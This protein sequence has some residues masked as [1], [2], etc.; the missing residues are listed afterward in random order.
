MRKYTFIIDIES[1]E[2]LGADS[3]HYLLQR[4]LPKKTHLITQVIK[5]EG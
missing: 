1:K 4:M 3:I 2:H 5:K